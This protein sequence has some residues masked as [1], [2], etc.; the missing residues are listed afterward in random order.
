M[1][2]Y[3]LWS[4]LP[5][6]TKHDLQ[7]WLASPYHNVREDVRLFY[8]YLRKHDDDSSISLAKNAV[9]AALYGD[10]PYNDDR[11][12]HAQSFFLK[13]IEAYLVYQTA[14]E[15]EVKKT[16]F[17]AKA[18]QNL[19]TEK[20]FL[21]TYQVLQ[22]KLDDAE[23]QDIQYLALQNDTEKLWFQHVVEK[24]RAAENNLQN[25]LIAQE[26]AFAADKLRT[27]CTAL[28]HQNVYKLAYDF[29]VLTPLL[30][31]IEARKWQETVPFI[32]AY[33][34]IFKMNTETESLP[35]FTA[36]RQKIS[37]DR[38]AFS[39]DELRNIY[40]FAINYAIK[41]SNKG[42]KTFYR[43][44]FELYKEGVETGVLLAKNSE[45]SVYTYKNAIAM[46]LRIGEMDYTLHFLEKYKKNLP[47]EQRR[48]YY[49]YNLARYYFTR[50]DFAQAM[51]L[52]DNLTYG[53]IFLQLDA[54]VMLLK[55]YY[56]Q[57]ELD[58]LDVHLRSF[59]QFLHRKRAT[60]GYHQQNYEN[61]IHCVKRLM[62]HNPFDKEER[63]A[64]RTEITDLQPL[65]ERAW[66]LA[67][68]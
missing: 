15:S 11:L 6:T 8:A 31:R 35:F 51:P 9:F 18:Y 58:A 48:N 13:A 16:F 40:L 24:E 33:Y 10:I 61:I 27:V 63:A 53:D 28:S 67:C 43:Q 52:L 45:L 57:E 60:L 1:K 20:P 17:L 2:L 21:Q 41:Q 25:I 22:K 37:T 5:R 30:E 26:K 4:A 55:I 7:E 65:T 34:F 44:L 42:D 29:G 47:A 12:R 46:G 56:E 66:L 50:R 36:L 59:K 62:A 14:H 54:K 38:A 68:L 49:E 64:L 32:G 39:N 3:S 19:Q 23:I